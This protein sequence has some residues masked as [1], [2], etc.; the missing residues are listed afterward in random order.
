M[1]VTMDIQGHENTEFAKIIVSTVTI[2]L[3]MLPV[4]TGA[5]QISLTKLMIPGL[6]NNWSDGNSENQAKSN[7]NKH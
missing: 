2:T 5:G 6:P 1:T 4:P 7:T 3:L